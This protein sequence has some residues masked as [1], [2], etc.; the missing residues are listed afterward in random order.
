MTR[1]GAEL[2]RFQPAAEQSWNINVIPANDLADAAEKI[3][4][5]VKAAA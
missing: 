4:A 5:A 3:V 2:D 1:A